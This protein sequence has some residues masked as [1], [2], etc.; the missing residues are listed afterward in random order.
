MTPPEKLAREAQRALFA[1]E[2]DGRYEV[3]AAAPAEGSTKAVVRIYGAIGDWWEGTDAAS[4]AGQIDS[5]DASEIEVHLNSPGGIAF[6]GIAVMNALRQH[7]ASVHVVV[8]GLAASA[9]SLIAMGG[10]KITMSPGSQLMIHNAS[11]LCYGQATEM[12]QVADV[13]DGVSASM[14][15]VYAQRGATAADWRAAM[16]AE[17]W[18]TAAE[19]VKA[20]LADE[21]ELAKADDSA[22]G[23]TSAFDL[24]I[25]AYAGRPS[26]PEPH[27]PP[28][29]PEEPNPQMEGVA[30]SDT[31]A[32]GLRE[33]LG[34]KADAELDEAGLLAALDEV[35]A[36]QT[37]DTTGAL[38]SGTVAIDKGTLTQLQADAALGRQAHEQQATD[39]RESLVKAALSDGRIPAAS[40]DH[41]RTLL[42]ADPNAATVLQSLAK[43]IVPVSETGNAGGDDPD[44]TD[45]D[46]DAEFR[47]FAGVF[48]IPQEG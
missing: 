44:N 41:W 31:L 43:G 14:A 8:D 23:A 4:L 24:T 46:L 11:G 3:T 20:G 45:H 28:A 2:P 38:P 17:T 6:D 7:P 39:Q 12:R 30:V 21:V 13:L 16:D 26:A 48:G 18:Y 22:K 42:K 9:A 32:K 1:K 36:E 27:M 10:D 37:T 40:A 25:F 29:R 15:E 19:A 47:A 5:L 35:L 33:R 34:T